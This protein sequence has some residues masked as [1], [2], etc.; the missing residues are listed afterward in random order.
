LIDDLT[1]EISDPIFGHRRGGGIQAAIEQHFDAAILVFR[2]CLGTK[3]RGICFRKPAFPIPTPL[4]LTIVAYYDSD[5]AKD[6]DRISVSG[7]IY[8]V[9]LPAEVAYA[10]RTGVNLQIN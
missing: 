6:W 8:S 1:T 2:Y 4:R 7:A 10:E 3:R 9:H 5:W